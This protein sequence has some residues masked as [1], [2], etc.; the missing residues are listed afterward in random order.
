M[1]A[2]DLAASQVEARADRLRVAL[3]RLLEGAL[4]LRRHLALGLDDEHL[5]QSF[6][7]IGAVRGQ[8]DRTAQGAR[9]RVWII[10]R[11]LRLGEEA[12]G[13]RVAAAFGDQ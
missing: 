9:R 11:H 10:R 4:R 8:L 12:V 13:F 7:E 3:Q 6:P 1:A 2:G 5:A